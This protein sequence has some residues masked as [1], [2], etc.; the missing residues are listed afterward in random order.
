MSPPLII[1]S[2]RSG[3]R[4]GRI[5]RWQFPGLARARQ[6]SVFVMSGPVHALGSSLS[7]TTSPL[8]TLRTIVRLRLPLRACFALAIAAGA[9]SNP[10]QKNGPWAPSYRKT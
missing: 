8:R 4:R 6:E 2:H 3:R 1:P 10:P 5:I 9:V 7:Q